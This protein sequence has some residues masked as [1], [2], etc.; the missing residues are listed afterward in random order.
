MVEKDSLNFCMAQE[1]TDEALSDLVQRSVAYVTQDNNPTLETVKMQLAFDLSYVQHE[2]CVTKELLMKDKKVAHHHKLICD[3]VPRDAQDVETLTTLYK[4]IFNLLLL[5]Q[6]SLSGSSSSSESSSGERRSMEREIAAALESV[7]PRIGLKYFIDL[8]TEDKITQLEELSHIV[9][10][11][12]MFNREMGKGG[13]GLPLTRAVI[14]TRVREFM[15]ALNDEIQTLD[16]M[17]QDYID[18]LIWAH[19][20]LLNTHPHSAAHPND[21]IMEDKIRRWQDELANRRQLMSCLQSLFEDASVSASTIE[22]AVGRL[23]V[24]LSELKS[25]VGS[26]VSV[27]K[28]TVYP[29]FEHLSQ[30][31]LEIEQTFLTILARAESQLSLSEFHTSITST[32]HHE[33]V[34]LAREHYPRGR[35]VSDLFHPETAKV[36]GASRPKKSEAKSEETQPSSSSADEEEST[37]HDD[38]NTTPN[39]N[40]LPVKLSIH[41]TPEFMQLPLEYQGY[42]PVTMVTR[43]GLLLPGDPAL[44]VIRYQNTYNVFINDHA[45]EAFLATP[46]RFT[47]GVL[48]LAHAKPHLIHLLR[49]TD[50]FPETSLVNLMNTRA[51]TLGSDNSLNSIHPLLAPVERQKVDASTST[52]THFQDKHLDFNYDWNEWAIRRKALKLVNLRKCKTISTQTQQSTFRKDIP[53]QVYLNYDNATQT[54]VNKGT[55]PPRTFTYLAG[56]RGTKTLSSCSKYVHEEE[57]TRAEAKDGGYR[58]PRPAMVK[59]TLDQ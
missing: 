43:D 4:H 25:A 53:S 31:G 42:C 21:S 10:G 20:P 55:N 29:M 44:G 34:R 5:A 59:Y 49:M 56:L 23:E 17:C 50:S 30:V 58:D 6:A 22:V 16:R 18:V 32:L 33:D 41:S 19:H 2:E 27:S 45:L 36:S 35:P 9:R 14:Q 38:A 7:F 11:I 46:D 24:A 28:E 26:R 39:N 54:A 12:R 40:S 3:L 47:S 57:D 51:S 15:D 8:K 37:T 1:L 52:P 48:A 13:A